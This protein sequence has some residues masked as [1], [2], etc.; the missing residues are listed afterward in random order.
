MLKNAGFGNEHES[1]SVPGVLPQRG[2]SPQ[3]PAGGLVAEQVSGTAFSAPRATNARTWMYRVRPSVQHIRQLKPID[4][5]LFVT[6][7]DPNPAWL[8]QS[9]WQPDDDPQPA[10]DWLAGITTMVTN[11]NAHL[12]VGGAIHTYA[13]GPSTTAAPVFVNTDAEMM[14]VPRVGRLELATELGPLT[15]EPGHIG[16]VPRGIKVRVSTPAALASGWMHENY[17]HAFTLPDPGVV[18]PNALAL[19]RDFHY[20]SAASEDGGPTTV[21][22]K[23]TGRFLTTTVDHTPLDV[24]AWRGN[25]APYTYDL[26]LF[27][28]LGAV[29]FDHPDPSLGTVLTSPSDLA[30]T[31]N[32]DLVIF[33]ERWVV[34]ED[35]FRPPWFHSNT[36]SEFMGLIDGSYD[37]KPGQSPGTMTLHNQHLPHGPD[38][39][40]FDAATA[41]ELTPQR[42]EPTLAFMLESRWVWQPTQWAATT[43]RLDADYDACWLPS[44]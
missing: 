11:G 27:S 7:P 36:M 8:A 2:N 9:R 39:T 35:T 33:R 37:A 25:Y 29:L 19:A 1:E 28:P 18:G 12:Q 31:A 6:A 23:S 38:T 40:A 22:V 15:V 34:A 32:I 43:D 26:R 41:A 42:L 24:V 14:F 30:G 16:V 3:Q 13:F 4:F 17:G 10:A 44:T 5:P 20:P 21:I